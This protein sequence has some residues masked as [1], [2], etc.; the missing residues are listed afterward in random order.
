MV[1]PG[2]SFE[3]EAAQKYYETA[4]RIWRDKEKEL[5]KAK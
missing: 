3:L 4:D 5:T 1:H 2:E